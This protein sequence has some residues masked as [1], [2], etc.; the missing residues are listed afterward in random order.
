VE[1]AVDGYEQARPKFERFATALANLLTTLLDASDLQYQQI[2]ARTKTVE[3]FR[4]KITREGKD[5]SD[6]LVDLTDLCGIRIVCYD[7]ATVPRIGNIISNNFCIDSRNSVD[8]AQLLDPDRFGYLSV[9]HVVSLEK[10][11]A[12]LPEYSPFAGLKAEIQVRTALQDAWAALD[13]SLRYKSRFDVPSPLRRR[14]YR[15]S[16]L[17]ELADDE[18][19]RLQ[20][21]SVA[22]RKGY[23]ADVT[24]GKLEAVEVNADS[25]DAF[26]RDEVQLVKDLVGAA[27]KA[28]FALAPSPPNQK[29]PWTMLVRT[30]DVAG[31]VTLLA[32]KQALVR[33][34]PRAKPSFESLADRW[35]EDTASP[36]LVLD[37]STLLRVAVLLSLEPDAARTVLDNVR[38]GPSL[39]GVLERELAATP[40]MRS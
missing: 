33:F 18:F 34:S 22:V 13:H 11:R 36:R 19:A 21:E 20:E 29:T 28:G 24:A 30:L 5:Y 9:H 31:L 23:A 3:S 1:Q 2:T 7:P 27:E 8:K 25:L 40:A 39:K 14:L 37:P 4:E 6:P 15:I 12:G 32:F 38:F 35:R 26:V 10:R 16:A 17:L